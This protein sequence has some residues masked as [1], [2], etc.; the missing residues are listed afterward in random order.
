MDAYT[1]VVFVLDMLN[2]LI[3]PCI[4]THK[5]T[6]VYKCHVVCCI[7]PF[8]LVSFFTANVMRQRGRERERRKMSDG[9]S[10]R[11]IVNLQLHPFDS[12]RHS[13]R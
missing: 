13:H 9:K 6:F 3:L 8:N 11:R 5:K 12:H 4:H 7:I 2:P 1:D 10:R